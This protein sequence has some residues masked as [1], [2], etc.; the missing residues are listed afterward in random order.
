[1]DYKH[2]LAYQPILT[3]KIIEIVDALQDKSLSNEQFHNRK[4]YAK[5]KGNLVSILEYTIAK[6][7]VNYLEKENDR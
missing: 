1:M 6:E 5:R 4:A 3:T 2:L 7:V